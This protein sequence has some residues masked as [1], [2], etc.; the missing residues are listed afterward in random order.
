M[1]LKGALI[2]NYFL[3]REMVLLEF[4]PLLVDYN[5]FI[6]TPFFNKNTLLQ[7]IL[8]KLVFLGAKSCLN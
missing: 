8:I 6:I 2:T 7:V 1:F 4:V 5:I 3:N